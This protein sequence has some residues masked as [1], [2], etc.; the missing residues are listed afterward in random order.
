MISDESAE[1]DGEE[2]PRTEMEHLLDGNLIQKGDFDEDDMPD[3]L[4]FG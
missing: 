4:Y 3:G 1:T 2:C